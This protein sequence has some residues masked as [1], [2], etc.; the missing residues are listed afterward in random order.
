MDDVGDGDDYDDGAGRAGQ[1]GEILHWYSN[2]RAMSRYRL[3][4]LQKSI[5]LAD[6]CFY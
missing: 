3:K 2:L 4:L 1:G 5:N 6:Y